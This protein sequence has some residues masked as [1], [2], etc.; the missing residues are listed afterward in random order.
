M[1]QS[2]P[3]SINPLILDIVS[4][5]VC[6][7]CY[8]HFRYLEKA[9]QS[10][11]DLPLA[12]RWRPFQLDSTIP[13]GGI[14]RSDY[15]INK[16]G[17]Q[18]R[19][20]QLYDTVAKEGESAG[21]DFA[22]DKIEIS[23]NTLDAHRVLHWAGTENLDIQHRLVERL[24]VIFFEEGGNLADHQTLAA[25]AEE[26]GMQKD[27]V[28][29]LLAGDADRDLVLEEIVQAN[30]MGVQGVPFTLIEQRYGL[31]GAQPPETLTAAL[32]NV[33]ASLKNNS[34]SLN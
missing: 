4:D 10:L 9:R 1:D 24:F 15:L 19:I 32:R 29:T 33:A 22:F 20:E 3:S 23:P 18:E 27:V 25:A 8:I 34:P 5:V 11:P 28:L 21:I 26:A 7:W 31:S 6:P 14:A 17:S 2:P 16:F 12:I 30:E 13:S